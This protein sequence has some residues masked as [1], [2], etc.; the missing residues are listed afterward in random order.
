[1]VMKAEK[2]GRNQKSK[3]FTLKNKLGLHAR[4][5]GLFAR[6]AA[7]FVSEIKI[8]KDGAE[9]DGKSIL[10]ILTLAAPFKAVIIVKA[11]GE[12][13]QLAIEELGRLIEK[14]FGEE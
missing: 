7:S 3:S 5:A 14:K 2:E 11:K 10:D 1:M 9:V 6:T 8:E 4:A 12:D 13:S